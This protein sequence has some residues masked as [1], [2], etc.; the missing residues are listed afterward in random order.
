MDEKFGSEVIAECPQY[1]H[2]KS[3]RVPYIVDAHGRVA[4][5]VDPTKKPVERPGKSKE[6]AKENKPKRPRRRVGKDVDATEGAEKG[7]AE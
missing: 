3:L 6:A 4:R 1:G 2:L 5:P 7:G